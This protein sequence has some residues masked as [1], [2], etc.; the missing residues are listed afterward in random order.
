MLQDRYRS[1]PQ[2]LSAI[3]TSWYAFDKYYKLTDETPVYAALILLHPS[4]RKTYITRH[5][6][7]KW[8][9]ASFNA[10]RK[11][12]EDKYIDYKVEK[13][14]STNYS[15]E[16]SETELYIRIL[17]VTGSVEDKY[18]DFIK[19]KPTSI[20]GTA[21]QQ[22]LNLIRQTNYPRLLQM[23]INILSIPSMSAEAEQVFSGGRRTITWD[24]MRLGSTNIEYTECLKSQLRSNITASGRLI[25]VDV[26]AKTLKRIRLAEQ[27]NIRPSQGSP[28]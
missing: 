15:T 25:A 19:A 5:W 27:L 24:R 8:H 7:K 6:N 26:V 16:P 14:A 23:A 11:L 21:L 18:K 20:Q 13:P 10:V 4:R 2:L 28:G 17:D 1:N 12:Q 3:I 22:Q 9:K